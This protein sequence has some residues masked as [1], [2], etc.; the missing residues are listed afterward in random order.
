MLKIRGC[1]DSPI[2]SSCLVPGSRDPFDG[3][4]SYPVGVLMLLGYNLYV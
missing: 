3:A 2:P 4:T 1:G